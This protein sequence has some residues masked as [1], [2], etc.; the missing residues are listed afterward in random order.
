MLRNAVVLRISSSTRDGFRSCRE[1]TQQT[2]EYELR[3]EQMKSC[4]I[5]FAG[6]N[7]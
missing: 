7:N 2:A 6:T 5:D 3:A 4:S 1:T